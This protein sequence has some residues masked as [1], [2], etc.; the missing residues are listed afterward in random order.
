MKFRRLIQFVLIIIAIS[1]FQTHP[2]YSEGSANTPTN[3]ENNN[4]VDQVASQNPYA[5]LENEAQNNVK[6]KKKVLNHDYPVINMG[7]YNVFFDLPKIGLPLKIVYSP[8]TNFSYGP[9]KPIKAIYEF[10]YPG[11]DEVTQRII[12]LKKSI[13]QNQTVAEEKKALLPKKAL[14]EK[15]EIDEELKKKVTEMKIHL[16]DLYAIKFYKTRI[17]KYIHDSADLYLNSYE[18]LP[19]KFNEIVALNMSNVLIVAEDYATAFPI[20][21]GLV[22]NSDSSI[23][24]KISDTMLEFYYMSKRYKKADDVINVK[25]EKKK[26]VNESK[27][28][29]L[30]T[31]DIYFLLNR[32]QDASEWYQSRLAPNEEATAAENLSWL[33]LAESLYQLGKYETS[34]KIFRAMEQYFDDTIYQD[35]IKFRIAETYSEKNNLIKATHNKA[36]VTWMRVVMASERFVKNPNLYTADNFDDMLDSLSYSS[37]LRPQVVLL[38]GYALRNNNQYYEAVDNFHA[39][40]IRAKNRYIRGALNKLIVETLFAKG[41]STTDAD[42]A[43]KFV[44]YVLT[45]KYNMRSENPEMIYQ[46]LYHN[47]DLIGLENASAELTLK[48]IDLSV[49]RKKDKTYLQLKMAKDMHDA[50]AYKQSMRVLEQIDKKLLDPYS[51]EEYNAMYIA[52]LLVTEQKATALDKLSKWSNEGVTPKQAYWIAYH[53]VQILYGQQRFEKAMDVINNIIGDEDVVNLPQEYHVFIDPIMAYQVILYNKLNRFNECLYVFFK[54][55]ERVLNTEIKQEIILAAI[56]SAMA[57][58]KDSEIKK[59]MDI[60]KFHMDEETYAW[61]DQWTKGK[62]WISQINRYLESSNLAI[63]KGEQL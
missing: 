60:A 25:I 45:L 14:K 38:K 41:M 47:L 44:R 11:V 6:K 39:L 54:E 28:F 43:Y 15:A 5:K 4:L 62:M 57:M 29:L 3:D 35:V 7:T 1:L 18:D 32:Y 12:T 52:N 61:L 46:L 37:K 22:K 30:R 17:E 24:S 55:Q 33:Y 9:Y 58:N 26:L 21:K 19:P 40:E 49:H 31:G 8:Y 27:T 13:Q 10:P 20:I 16:A 36:I 63:N 51:K 42:D 34:K 48:I 50:F 59:L 53:K 2:V 56:S 23:K